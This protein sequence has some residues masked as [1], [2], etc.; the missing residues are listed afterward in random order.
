VG[1]KK[2]GVIAEG[3]EA[4]LVLMSS[5]GEVLKTMVRGQGF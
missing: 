3:A 4:N 2:C 5:A 1:L